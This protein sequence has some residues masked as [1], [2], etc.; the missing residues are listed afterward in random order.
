MMRQAR[1]MLFGMSVVLLAG[2]AGCGGGAAARLDRGLT[3]EAEGEIL[4]AALSYISALERDL[5]LQE[6]SA[7]LEG[8]SPVLAEAW[9]GS[10]KE[11]LAR[12]NPLG[13]ADVTLVMDQI[14]ARA[15]GVGAFVPLPPGWDRQRRQVLDMG[16]DAA[17]EQAES[18]AGAGRWG[19]GIQALSRAMERYE[20]TDKHSGELSDRWTDYLLGWAEADLQAGRAQAALG[21]FEEARGRLDW[22]DP[23]VDTAERGRS[24]AI[25]AATTRVAFLPVLSTE[26]A[27]RAA[28]RGFQEGL[29]ETLQFSWWA[30]P[31][32]LIEVSD[33]LAVRREVD[34][35]QR[36]Q[37]RGRG[38]DLLDLAVQV[39]RSV[40]ADRVVLVEVVDFSQDTTGIRMQEREAPL[41]SGRGTETFQILTGNLRMSATSSVLVVDPTQRRLVDQRRF[42]LRS[43]ARLEAGI[44]EGDPATLDLP[45]QTRIIFNG[46]EQAIRESEAMAELQDQVAERLAQEAFERLLARIP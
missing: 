37:E 9:D 33:P 30:S 12:E 34:R 5:T 44:Y 23:R 21:R 45:V 20:P 38:P 31:P 10:V 25:D 7:R 32:R 24:R 22:E 17:L 3:Q 2:S 28:P 6:A 40:G 26:Q 8:L 46:S 19:D 4:Q 1:W 43:Q 15:P 13:A 35:V 42:T 41:R 29:T 27:L 18:A 14:V 16:L 39:G 36:Q 11:F